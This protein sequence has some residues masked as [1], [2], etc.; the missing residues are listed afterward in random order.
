[1][2]RTGPEVEQRNG[3]RRRPRVPFAHRV[4]DGDTVIYVRQV[5]SGD[6]AK[7]KARG[8]LRALGLRGIGDSNLQ[9]NI[10]ETHGA[11]DRVIQM[12]TVH[13]ITI[14]TPEAEEVAPEFA[15]SITVLPEPRSVE[16]SRYNAGATGRGTKF[17][18]PHGAI[19]KLERYDDY[20][21][22]LWPTNLDPAEFF[23]RISAVYKLGAVT[24]TI[25]A[26]GSEAQSVDRQGLAGVVK[27]LGQS[28]RIIRMSDPDSDITVGWQRSP[29][30]K[31]QP[32]GA[33][34]APT[35]P[36]EDLGVLLEATAVEDV[37]QN[38]SSLIG[39]VVESK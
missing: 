34:S 20:S 32:Q 18:M 31:G 30:S 37:V 27:S 29:R 6:H 17:E 4:S 39:M 16:V 5:R 22:F 38:L 9:P 8:T 23:N 1:M 35:L 26:R 25:Y 3:S 7:P 12:V 28:I 10:P 33:I 14:G 15:E 19:A 2:V 24:C 11:I 36:I 21:T 13:V